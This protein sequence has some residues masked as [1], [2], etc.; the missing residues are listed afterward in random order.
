[1]A[2]SHS[3]WAVRCACLLGPWL[4]GCRIAPYD[5]YPYEEPLPEAYE[6]VGELPGSTA[7]TGPAEPEGAFAYTS[8]GSL[9]EL[10]DGA[11]NPLPL[12]HT[13]VHAELIGHVAAVQVRQTFHNASTVPIE[14]VYAFPLPENSAVSDMRMVIGERV[15]ASEIMHR[16]AARETYE[17]ARDQ[18]YTAALL[19]QERPNVFTQSVANIAPGEDI[20]VEI[21]YLQTLTYDSGEYEFVFPMVIGPRFVPPGGSVPDAARIRPPVAGPGTRTGHDISIEVDVE[22]GPPVVA[23]T[24]PTHEVEA[25]EDDGRLRVTLADHDELPNRDFVLRYRVAGSAPRAAVLVDEPAP[26]ELGHYLMVIHPPEIDVDATVGRREVI[27]VVDRSGSMQG[28]PLALAKQTARELLARLRPVDTFDVVGFAN[29]TARLFG[30]PR[31]ANDDNLAAALSFI[32]GM[33]GSGG[34]MMDDAV[35]AALSDPVAP[36]RNRY[37]L[38]LTDGFVGNETE[39]FAGARALVLRVAEQGNVARVF[40]IGIGS[41]P[42]RYLI[43]GLSVAG[44]G[45]PRDVSLREHP[46]RVV[47]ALMHDIDHAVITE[48]RLPEDDPLAGDHYPAELPA[49]FASRP[50][51]VMGR[52]Q[53]SPDALGSTVV[54][55]GQR[56]GEAVEIEAPVLRTRGARPLYSVLWARAKVEELSTHLWYGHDPV[57]VAQITQLGL[58]YSIVTPFTSFVAVDRTRTVGE[59]DPQRIEQPGELAEGVDARA[60]G[61]RTVSASRSVPYEARSDGNYARMIRV[62]ANPV[63]Q[64]TAVGRT[65][66]MEEMRTIPVGNSTSRDYTQVVESAPTAIRDAAGISLAGT[67]GAESKYVVEGANVGNPSFGT[68]G[69]TIVQEFVQEVEVQEAGYEAEFGGAAGGQVMARRISGTNR[70]RGSARFTVTPRLAAPRFIVS[71][72]DAVRATETPDFVLQGVITAAG[73]IVKDH[74]FWSAGISATGGRNSLVQS[75]HHRVDADGSGG[76]MGCPYEN[77][78]QDC[79][80]GTGHIATE[81]FA[82]QR[83]RTGAV[84]GGYTL[85]LDWYISPR[86]RLGLTVMGNP[87]FLRRSYRGEASDPFDPTLIADPQGGRTLVSNGVVNGHMGWDRRHAITTGLRYLGRM[88]DDHI[89]IDAMAAYSSF[90]NETAWRLDDPSQRDLPATQWKTDG[91][92]SLYSLLDRDGALDLVPGVTRACNSSA[93]PGLACPVRSWLSGGIGQYGVDRSQRAE[94]AAALTHYFN[95]AGSHQLKYGLAFEHLQR[96]TVARYSGHNGADFA[97]RCDD[98]GLGGAASDE[99]GEWCFDEGAGEYRLPGGPRVDGHRYVVADGADPER[100]TTLGFGRVRTEQGELSAIATPEGQGVRVPAYDQTLSSQGYAVFLQDR[101]ALL[102]NL[103]LSAGV[104]W[105]LQDM[106]DILGDRAVLI[107]DNVAP[108]LG[109]VYDWTDEGR[110]R[111]FAS[112]G[113]FYQPMPLQLGSRTFGGLVNVRRSYRDSDCRGQQVTIGGETVDLERGGQ[114]TEHCTDYGTSTTPLLAGAVVPRLRGQ[115]NEQIQAGYEHEVIEDLVLGVR[116]LHSDL[117]R[118]VEDV[119]TNGGADYIVANPGV[120]VARED[121]ARQQAECARLQDQL[122]GLAADDPARMSVG[123][124]LDRCNFLVDAF[125]KVDSLFERPRRRYHALTFELRKRFARNWLLLGSYTYSRLIGNYDGFVDPITGMINL[126]ASAQYDLPELVRNSFGRLSIDSP[127]RIK[128]DG[129]YTFDLRE[130]GRL[131]LGS[132]LRVRSGFPISLRGGH[133]QYVGAPVYVL[134][135]GAGGRVRPSYGWNLS[136]SYAYPLPADLEIEAAVRIINITNAKA[137]LRVDEIYSYQNARPVAGGELSDLKHTKIV[138][139]SDPR[140]FYQRTVLPRQGNFG[141]ETSFQTPLAASF[142]LQLRF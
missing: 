52:Y 24:A 124:E 102:S 27:L 58:D 1:M 140:A 47:E 87:Q 46:A 109:V 113:W 7:W 120:E 107:R 76:F 30:T 79:A 93:S 22:A 10:R 137:T 130:A 51:V 88:A 94:L 60:S 61:A 104:R 53:G 116:W 117:G 23:W 45:V 80:P 39:I 71:T 17:E 43:D 114:P 128:L 56:D 65:V 134:P 48:L 2:A 98:L 96:R 68:V 36:G 62:M 142:E 103:F 42:N 32:D 90:A 69:A 95:A 37:V 41:S 97:G 108:R 31:P 26:G 78:T 49:L 141:T 99:G 8:P 86:H 74:L 84:G 54:L 20:D 11:G 19:E 77:G 44:N 85:G 57:V 106:R 101:W 122:D 123:R 15:I 73:P 35:Q 67:T 28:E 82:D 127:H 25:E 3:G 125:E 18:G 72:D 16:E 131:T 70:V 5:P 29:G 9:P 133:E 75:F 38:F 126:G 136:L 105:E 121:I 129:F 135:R 6:P 66:S 33:I 4:L 139:A 34:T 12:R 111:L 110:S 13:G 64:R 83:F 118:A 59:G 132:S 89:E 92:A 100:R 138:S 50:V 115:Y 40:G 112:Y 119:S 21:R 55:H 91:G 14:V 63:E 81:R